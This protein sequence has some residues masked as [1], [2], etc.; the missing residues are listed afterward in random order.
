MKSLLTDA[1]SKIIPILGFAMIVTSTIPAQA[2]AAGVLAPR[3]K[4]DCFRT[5]LDRSI[6]VPYLLTPAQRKT[7]TYIKASEQAINGMKLAHSLENNIM[8]CLRNGRNINGF[9]RKPIPTLV[10]YPS[11]TN[12]L[13]YSTN[14]TV[15]SNGISF[16]YFGDAKVN[17]GY[18]P[19]SGYTSLAEV[20]QVERMYNEFDNAG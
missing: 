19:K 3:V 13:A 1:M 12:Y 2:G 9:E 17:V 7:L 11:M 20:K 8:I 14:F 16:D 18:S 5:S 10:A 15:K 4:N 6:V